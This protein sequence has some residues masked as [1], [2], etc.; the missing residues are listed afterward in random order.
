MLIESACS[1]DRVE[2]ALTTLLP[3][4]PD[5]HYFRFNPGEVTFH[6]AGGEILPAKVC[7]FAFEKPYFSQFFSSTFVISLTIQFLGISQN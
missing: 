5:V 1:V 4:L 7:F 2:E 3:L 6:V